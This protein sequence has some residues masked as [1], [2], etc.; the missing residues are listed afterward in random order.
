MPS[1]QGEVYFDPE[2]SQNFKDNLIIVLSRIIYF[3]IS[4]LYQIEELKVNN[5]ELSESILNT[6]ANSLEPIMTKRIRINFLGKLHHISI[7]KFEKQVK[8][9]QQKIHTQQNYQNS[10]K[11]YLRWLISIVFPIIIEKWDEIN[12][13]KFEETIRKDL[14]NYGFNTYREEL[15]QSESKKGRYINITNS[16]R[17]KLYYKV[18]ELTYKF[19]IKNNLTEKDFESEENIIKILTQLKIPSTINDIEN[20]EIKNKKQAKARLKNKKDY[21]SV[22]G[23]IMINIL[24]F[25]CNDSITDIASKYNV[26][27]DFITKIARFL[28]KNHR[29]KLKDRFPTVSARGS[30]SVPSR[31]TL[32]E[33]K[34][35]SLNF[36]D[37]EF[38]AEIAIE[39][40]NDLITGESQLKVDDLPL[41]FKTNPKYLAIS[42][43]YYA[44]RHI[45]YCNK[46]KRFQSY[47]ILEFINEHFSTNTTMNLAISNTVPALYNY[48]SEGLKSKILYIPLSRTSRED[49]NR[50][51]FVAKLN[52]I[53]EEYKKTSRIGNISL[54]DLFLNTLNYYKKGQ[55]HQFIKD[56]AFWNIGKKAWRLVEKLSIPDTLRRESDLKDFVSSYHELI[57]KL[58]VG[59][60]EKI[61]LI[62]LLQNFKEK[63]YN[64]Y[65]Y[66]SSYKEK[67]RREYKRFLT[68]NDFFFLPNSRIKRFL[69]VLGFSPYDGFDLWENKIHFNGKLKIYANFHHYHYDPKEQS[70]NDLVFI[71]IKPPKKIRTNIYKEKKILTHNMISGKEGHLKHPRVSPKMKQ[72]IREELDRIEKRIEHNAKLLE[73]SVLTLQ[74]NKLNNLI[75]WSKESIDNAKLRLLD[76]DFTW[77][78]GIELSIP[79]TKKDENKEIDRN[80]VIEVIEQIKSDRKSRI[81][82]LF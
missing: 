53:R 65:N 39:I 16:F 33:I 79:L 3:N 27:R 38:L 30:G 69:L 72:K 10:F 68:Y 61:K 6:I 25:S 31:K 81:L 77:T 51:T 18:R 7:K 35:F 34:S 40:F 36:E 42:L 41:G 20:S 24:D 47:G 8:K 11:I 5:T 37:A 12:L 63:R 1:S 75:N 55:F 9:L 29:F 4:N 48:I 59:R 45:D 21:I 66:E 44:L 17:G 80:I 22:L 76:T 58:K 15:E 57:D 32:E 64:Y 43:I 73:E 78:K 2:F 28:A 49:Y 60:T 74:V 13:P 62:R 26:S 71:P 67:K 56:L 82:N 14:K 46:Y 54:I 50:S 23:K 52:D 19:I 70:E